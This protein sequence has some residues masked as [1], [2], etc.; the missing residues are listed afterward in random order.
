VGV[1]G[2]GKTTL[3]DVLAGR[4]TCVFFPLKLLML[5]VLIS[6]LCIPPM[7]DRCIMLLYLLNRLH[8][9]SKADR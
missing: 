2:A 9:F 4:K 1:S 8:A 5:S 7:Y 6:G 3:M